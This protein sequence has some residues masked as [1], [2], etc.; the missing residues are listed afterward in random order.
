MVEAEFLS[1]SIKLSPLALT[2]IAFEIESR[3]PDYKRKL[4]CE[5]EETLPNN[6]RHFRLQCI[7]KEGVEPDEEYS[8]TWVDG[9]Q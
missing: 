6:D 3:F 8:N 5:L 7:R 1:T 9:R 4:H 2:A